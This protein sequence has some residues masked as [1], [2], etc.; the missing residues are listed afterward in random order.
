MAGVVRQC[1]YNEGQ[2]KNKNCKGWSPLN[3]STG[4]MQDETQ[5]QRGTKNKYQRALSPHVHHPPI[6]PPEC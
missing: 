3:V 4:Q 6:I 5:E 1:D 2:K